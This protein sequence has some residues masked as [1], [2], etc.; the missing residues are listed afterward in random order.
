M[1]A[2]LIWFGKT[3]QLRTALIF[4]RIAGNSSW[5]GP[6]VSVGT[7]TRSK[8]LSQTTDNIYY[9]ITCVNAL[10]CNVFQCIDNYRFFHPQ[11]SD[12]GPLRTGATRPWPPVGAISGRRLPR[13]YGSRRV[14]TGPQSSSEA[15]AS[16]HREQDLLRSVFDS[17]AVVSGV[18]GGVAGLGGGENPD[19]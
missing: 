7:A 8:L 1:Y 16:P 15:G 2:T 9:D 13:R 5:I 19:G 11:A 4:F 10:H 14:T 6:E 17:A 12:S 18:L 3:G